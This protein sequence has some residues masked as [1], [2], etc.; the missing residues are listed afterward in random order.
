MTAT[1]RDLMC[2]WTAIWGMSFNISKCK[3]M[4]VGKNNPCYEYTMRGVKLR[5]T[6]EEGDIGVVITKNL[7]PSEQCSKAAG[8]ATSVLNQLK[9][10]FHYRLN[11]VSIT[12]NH[13]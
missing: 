6:E 10:N 13:T 9:R 5:G 12:S 8:R 11:C 1:E 2:D 7:K 3:I 4:H